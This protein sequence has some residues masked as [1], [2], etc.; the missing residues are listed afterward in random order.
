MTKYEKYKDSGIEWI[1]EIPEHWEVDKL[2]WQGYFSAS[3]IDKK[4]VDG[5]PSVN[6]VNYTDIYGNEKR[7]LTADKEYMIV[8]CPE[9][10][11]ITHQVLKGDLLFTP[12]SETIEDI[13]LSALVIEDL[14]NTVFSYHV[15]RLE[16]TKDFDLGFRKYLCNNNFVLNQFSREAKGTTRQIIGRDVFKKIDIV[17]P[18]FVEQTAIANY[19]DKKTEE[20]DELIKQKEELLLLFE[21]EKAATINQAVTKGINPN[22]KLKDSKIEWL[23]E[24]PEHWKVDKLG[25][26][27]YFSASGIDKKN[28]EGEPL[29][30]MVNYTD[31]YGNEKRIL[32]ADKEYMIVSCPEEK[33]LTHQVLKGDLLFTPS[34]ETIE[35][36][37]LSA[38]VIED[39]PNTVFSYHVIRLQFTKD[40]DL[41]FRKYLCNN[42]F[43]LNQFSREAKGTTR[44]IIGRDVFKK[45]DIVI[46]PKEEQEQIVKF[47]NI[48]S[49]RIENK[50]DLA[51]N[52]IELLKEYKTALISEVSTGKIKVI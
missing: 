23:G 42:N 45:I 39:L 52:L 31:I 15:I 9:E 28:V 1:G 5:E 35:D 10:K 3:G 36:I 18:P 47:I 14:P 13:G 41:G 22:V 51:K 2:G 34:S 29:V 38:L 20:I 43:V 24:I 37:G 17:I 44:K 11:A 26:Q 50:F 33:A 12:S 19:L 32:T 48:E 40:F 30:N 49:K 8:S 21:E 16:F 27:G 7:I 4:S 25:W 6:M 46:P